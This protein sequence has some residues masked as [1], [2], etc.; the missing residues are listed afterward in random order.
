MLRI[1]EVWIDEKSEDSLVGLVGFW[2]MYVPFRCGFSKEL[3]V[4]LLNLYFRV[5]ATQKHRETD[6]VNSQAD[7]SL[8]PSEF[9]TR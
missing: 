5:L 1:D 7:K 9:F 4:G 2:R 3:M 6:G 8:I